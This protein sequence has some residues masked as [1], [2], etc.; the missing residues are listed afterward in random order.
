MRNQSRNRIGTLKRSE[1]W[2]GLIRTLQSHV[3]IS[4]EELHEII[5]RFV[6]VGSRYA[7]QKLLRDG[8][9][10]KGKGRGWYIIASPGSARPYVRNPYEIIQS[11]FG[12]EAVFCYGTAMEIHGLSRYGWVSDYYVAIGYSRR[13]R[14]LDEMRVRFV[15]LKEMQVGVIVS[16]QSLSES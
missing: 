15:Q 8:V 5:N 6:L 3:A 4:K 2:K 1:N 16:F 14:Q 12:K 9:I 10:Q 7:I 13:D 11:I